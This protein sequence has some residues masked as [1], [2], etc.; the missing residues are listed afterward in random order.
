MLKIIL[1]FVSSAIFLS[2]VVSPRD[3]IGRSNMQRSETYD[4]LSL[5]CFQTC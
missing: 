5:D 3:C 1:V 4:K 2:T